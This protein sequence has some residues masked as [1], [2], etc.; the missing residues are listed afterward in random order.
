MTSASCLDKDA[1][2]VIAF[3][4]KCPAALETA[5]LQDDVF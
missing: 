4:I 1:T 3:S 5:V 2:P